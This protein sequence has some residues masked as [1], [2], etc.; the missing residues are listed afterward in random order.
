V[1]T[2]LRAARQGDEAVTKAFDPFD[3]SASAMQG[4]EV[5][6]PEP[7]G[8]VRVRSRRRAT[9]FLQVPAQIMARLELKGVSMPAWCVLCVLQRLEFKARKK[10]EPIT[11]SNKALEIFAVPRKVKL[12]ALDEL[13][14]REFIL[15]Y[16]R[17]RNRS[18]PRVRMNMKLQG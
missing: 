6:E 4:E 5:R 2:C 16:T 17:G 14:A 13:V 10:G 7:D 9:G 8:E 3:Y 18:C 1:G 12:R 15:Q 11:L